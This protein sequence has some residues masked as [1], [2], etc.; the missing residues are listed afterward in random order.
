M[1]SRANISQI[2]RYDLGD[3]QAY[4]VGSERK[5]ELKGFSSNLGR[6]LER[7]HFKGVLIDFG[8]TLAY[9][10]EVENGRYEEALVSTLKKY[11]CE[12]QLKDVS[13][14]LASTYVSSTNGELKTPQE[15]WSLILRK[16]R[17]PAQPDLMSG[18]EAVRNSHISAVWKLY[19]GVFAVLTILQK[20]YRLALVSNCAVRTDK[21]IGSLGLADFFSCTI[22]SYQ[23]GVRKP[24]KRMY[25]EALRCLELEAH[26]CI[27]V[28]DEISDLEGA[29]EVGL[30]TMLVRQGLSTF[31]EA[32]NVNFKPNFQIS[33]ISEITRFL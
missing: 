19:D 14:V 31:Q 24:D 17:I 3:G 6:C 21:L 18:L 7:L 25:L 2:C 11:G 28:A 30:K 29:R 27:F 12:R 33:Q 26:E 9:V 5:T 32:K 20:K 23:V 1:K 15:F 8:G 10:D 22:L 13:S 16:L 4:F